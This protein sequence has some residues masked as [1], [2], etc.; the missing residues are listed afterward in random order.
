MKQVT[1]QHGHKTLK[2]TLIITTKYSEVGKIVNE[3]K[4]E[5][6]ILNTPNFCSFLKAVDKRYKTFKNLRQSQL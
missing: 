6:R 4:C 3:V 5:L 2:S 1:S